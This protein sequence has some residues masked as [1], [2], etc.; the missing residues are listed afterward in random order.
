MFTQDRFAATLE[1]LTATEQRYFIR[2][3]DYAAGNRDRQPTSG[4]LNTYKQRKLRRQ[5]GQVFRSLPQEG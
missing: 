5:A 2:C 1:S 3:L 4:V